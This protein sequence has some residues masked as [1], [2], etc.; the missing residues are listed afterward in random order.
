MV[1][2]DISRYYTDPKN[3]TYHLANSDTTGAAWCLG[4]AVWRIFVAI[5][6]KG[7]VKFKHLQ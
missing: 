5:D 7:G 1:N 4:S 3:Y 6:S 2:F